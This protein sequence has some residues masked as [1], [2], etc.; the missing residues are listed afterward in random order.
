ME[1]INSNWTDDAGNHA[2]G[3]STGI[4]STL[5]SNREPVLEGFRNGAFLIDVLGACIDQLQYFQKSKFASDENA[6]ALV[7]L[8]AGLEC[9]QRRLSRR[10][11]EGVLGTHRLDAVGAKKEPLTF[12][13][14]QQLKA[15]N[16][17]SK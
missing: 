12:A 13:E 1:P 14:L 6:E 5:P 4:G 3:Q 7:H 2:G 8:E 16:G 9:L 11:A 17:L 15:V 10:K